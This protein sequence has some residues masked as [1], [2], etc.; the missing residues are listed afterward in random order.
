[1][2]PSLHPLAPGNQCSTL[3]FYKFSF[4][5]SAGKRHHIVF[6]FLWLISLTILLKRY[7]HVA[8]NGRIS[9][10]LWPNNIPLHICHV[11]CCPFINGHWGCFHILAIVNNAAM[12]MRVQ[13][14]FRILFSFPLDIFPEMGLLHHMVVLLL[15][16]EGLLHCFLQWLY[17][18]TF[19]P[20]VHG[21]PFL[22]HPWKTLVIS[23]LFSSSHWVHEVISHCGLDLHFPNG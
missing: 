11:F 15:V 23:Y 14:Y 1:M 8:T 19:P 18:F 13:I 10:F 22:P 9:S 4:L 17:Q 3:C 5:D 6:V 12:N 7:I 21:V 16:L 20:T 2:S